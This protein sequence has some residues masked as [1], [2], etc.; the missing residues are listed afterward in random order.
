MAVAVAIPAYNETDRIDGFLLEIDEALS[1]SGDV[2]FVLAHDRS[3][4]RTREVLGA[5]DG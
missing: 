5:D 3:T 1:Q 2:A 4:E